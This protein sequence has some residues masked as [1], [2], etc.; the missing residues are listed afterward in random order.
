MRRAV[1]LYNPQSGLGR[2]RRIADVERAASVLR[3]GGI[4]VKCEE[5]TGPRSAAQQARRL[6]AAGMD[7]IIACGGDGT[8]NDTLQ[9][10]A[11]TD[12]N[13]GVLPLGTANSLACDLGIPRE[14]EVAA[15]Q[16]L[17]AQPHRI[18][19][20]QV[21]FQASS[22]KI[23]SRY[24]TVAAG[25]G[26]D[27][28]LFYQIN[29]R[30]KKRWGMVAYCAEAFRQWAL[31]EFP[32]FHAE[33]FDTER[34]ERRAATVTQV[35]VVRIAD[36]GGVLRRLAPGADLLRDDFRVVLFKT[37]SRTRYLRFATG[38]MIGQ[39]WDDPMIELVYA[40]QVWCTPINPE[41]NA[42]HRVIHAEVDGEWLGRIPVTI[43]AVP[44]AVNLLIPPGATSLRSRNRELPDA[45]PRI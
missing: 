35:L 30:F 22:A 31:H 29:A 41:Q 37:R 9:G 1:L 14:V 36:F 23:D 39:A 11:G 2:A 25:V 12:A 19:V 34:G 16:L 42:P 32:P 13:L 17:A 18:A 44:A 4:E 15:H 43:S 10:V 8:V 7:T 26:A 20:G 6:I 3:A 21:E 45:V 40:S 28:A 24:F 5:T 33:W 27:A 38:R